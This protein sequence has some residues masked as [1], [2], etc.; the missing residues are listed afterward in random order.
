MTIFTN[1]LLLCMYSMIS[2]IDAL[3]VRP[4]RKLSAMQ[5]IVFEGTNSAQHICHLRLN[6][7]CL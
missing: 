3:L 5:T 2:G 1:M 4:V 7:Y 6:L